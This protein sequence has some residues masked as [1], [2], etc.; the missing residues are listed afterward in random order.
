MDEVE[1]IVGALEFKR[2]EYYNQIHELQNSIKSLSI[3]CED[4]NKEIK[5]NIGYGGVQKLYKTASLKLQLPIT[6]SYICGGQYVD[7]DDI[8]YGK[9]PNYIV[10]LGYV[11]KEKTF[12]V[13]II[14]E[15]IN[16][17]ITKGMESKHIDYNKDDPEQ[18]PIYILFEKV[19]GGNA[20]NYSAGNLPMGDPCWNGIPDEAM[21]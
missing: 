2:T 1:R 15:K 3:L 16:I 9:V 8:R 11:L 13:E 18:E 21:T 4:L 12:R 17:R 7:Y 10:V 5:K 14:D 20:N 6:K 19:L